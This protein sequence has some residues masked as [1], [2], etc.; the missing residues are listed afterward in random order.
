[1]PRILILYYS[2]S[3]N[4]RKMAE[5]V[6]EGIRSIGGVEVDVKYYV[7]VEDLA[8]YDAIV[9]GAPTYNHDLPLEI[10]MVFREASARNVDLKGKIGAAFGSYGWSGEAPNLVL[11]IM[12]RKFEMQII[13][14]PLLVRYAPGSADLEKC[15][16]LGMEIAK[17]VLSK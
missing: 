15:K 4:T 7:N 16:A 6:A 1:M 13:R 3:G 14:P 11:E 10:S 5:A 2:A 17:R 9:I 8:G 12:E